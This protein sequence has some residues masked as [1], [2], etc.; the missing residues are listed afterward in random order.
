MWIKNVKLQLDMLEIYFEELKIIN[1]PEL[2]FIYWLSA[3]SPTWIYHYTD[4][5]T[6]EI[7]KFACL[8]T[9][10]KGYWHSFSF[11]LLG[12]L[13]SVI[14]R[15]CFSIAIW[16][17][18]GAVTSNSKIW[19]TGSFLHF[20]FSEFTLDFI[21]NTFDRKY[22]LETKRFDIACD[23]PESKKNIEKS[24]TSKITSQINYNKDLEEYETL[25]IWN[26]KKQTSFI[27][28]YD[29]ILDTIKKS[30]THLYNFE[31][32]K[33]TRVEVEFNSEYIKWI[34][35][36]NYWIINYENLLSNNQLLKDI[37]LSRV[38]EDMTF[39]T[40][41]EYYDYKF[42]YLKPSRIDLEKYY[43]KHK[44]LPKWWKKNALGMFKKLQEII[45]LK[46]LF[47]YLELSSSDVKTILDY[48]I[49]ERKNF[50]KSN[51]RLKEKWHK[52]YYEL[53]K[54]QTEFTQN[55]NNLL[56]QENLA[57]ATEIKEVLENA[58]QKYEKTYNLKTK[59]E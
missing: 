38:S 52:T 49:Y 11:D 7:L 29:K 12:E 21:N 26:R 16:R 5:K 22:L 41:L 40:N 59:N 28:I 45:W 23:I 44:Q 39:F 10:F 46:N 32:D 42:T 25:Y 56:L 57:E 53:I 24:I 36:D 34:N 8:L 18:Q 50:L 3:N 6:G 37:F 19:I 58:I 30:K 43:L 4:E 14:I 35:K 15:W 13:D 17:S 55:I 27:R 1:N 2:S 47:E 48:Y 20:F 51:I 54:E 9:Q 33:M 31:E